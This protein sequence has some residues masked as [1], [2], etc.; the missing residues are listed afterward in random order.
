M[1]SL[2]CHEMNNVLNGMTLQVAIMEQL[3]RDKSHADITRMRRLV[4]EATDLISRLQKHNH[5]KPFQEALDVNDVV[6]SARD[7]MRERYPEARIELELADGRCRV[8]ADASALKRILWLLG[9]HS[10]SVA[11]ATKPQIT[12]TT[13]I[14][15]NRCLL[16]WHDNGPALA[17]AAMEQLFEPFHSLREGSDDVS[18]PVLSLL[19][20]RV[21]GSIKAARAPAGGMNFILE[22]SLA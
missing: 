13:R 19:A 22:L 9:W 6:R 14:H 15:G 1:V 20:R 2:V 4:K 3:P 11:S 21:R 7:A 16:T 17:D 12:I 10:V 18:L 5:Q 8:H